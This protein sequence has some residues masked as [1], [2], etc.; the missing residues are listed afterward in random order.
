MIWIT[1]LVSAAMIVAAGIRL[2]IYADKLSEYIKVG[3]VWIGVI[4]LGL[5]TSLPEAVTSLIAVVNLQAPNLAVGNL[6]GSNNFNPML[7]VVMDMVYRKGSVTSA[8][9]PKASHRVSAIYAMMLT[10]VVMLE[11]LRGQQ[12]A[13]PHIGPFSV[14]GLVLITLYVIGMM[15][16][17]TLSDVEHQPEEAETDQGVRVSLP[18]IWLNL[19][20]SAVV[21]VGGAMLLANTADVIAVQTGLGRT[22]VGSIFLALV[23]S[24]P[25]MVVTLSAMRLGSFDLAVGNIFGSNMT[26]IFIVVLCG[27][28]FSNVPMLSVVSPSHVL[29]GGISLLLSAIILIGIHTKQ[30]WTLW[31]MGWNSWLML[32]VFLAGTGWLYQMR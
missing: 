26:N 2:T 18:V 4:L 20:I 31:S 14:G 17:K 13:L 11:I 16:I 28:F 29:T 5:V 30:K 3:K 22:F 23:T 24:L 1:F 27:L 8:I 21:V 7:L 25:E 32:I 6:V 10:G 19:F 15:R 12:V 9:H